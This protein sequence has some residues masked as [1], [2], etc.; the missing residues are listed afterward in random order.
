LVVGRTDGE[1]ELTLESVIVSC[2]DKENNMSRRTVWKD[3]FYVEVY[4]LARSGLKEGQMAA[5]LGISLPTFRSWERKKKAFK[6]AIQKGR[7]E[8]RGRNNK[9][10]SFEDYVYKRLS[11]DLRL[12]WNRI[13]KLD[14]KKGGLEKIE[15]ILDR[16]GRRVRQE[17]FLHAWISGNFSISEA[18][19]KVNISRNTLERWK[20]EDPEFAKLVKQIP[21]Y[22]KNFFEDHLSRLVAGGDSS[23]II[24]VNRTYN[25]DRGYNEKFDIDMNLSGE[26]NQNVMSVDV[27][28]LPLETRKEIL[29]SLRKNKKN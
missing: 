18:L 9:T 5:A 1:F 20:K 13:C 4:N 23:A 24:F 27:L 29:K 10:A 7:K 12:T 22:R 15:A 25:R 8:Y 14:K 19:R 17:L 26:L 21:W 3:D 16:K 28:K 2:H 6:S 11:K